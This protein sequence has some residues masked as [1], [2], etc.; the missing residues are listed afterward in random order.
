MMGDKNRGRA[1]RTREWV[2]L[3]SMALLS[4]FAIVFAGCGCEGGGDGDGNDNEGDDDQEPETKPLWVPVDLDGDE[5]LDYVLERCFNDGGQYMCKI[6]VRSVENNSLVFK[7]DYYPSIP[8]FFAE[9]NDY[10]GDSGYEIALADHYVDPGTGDT[11]CWVKIWDTPSFDLVFDFEDLCAYPFPDLWLDATGDGVLDVVVITLDASNNERLE[12]Y[13]G[14]KDFDLAWEFDGASGHS[15]VLWYGAIKPFGYYGTSNFGEDIPEGVVLADID[16]IANPATVTFHILDSTN[17]NIKESSDSYQIGIGSYYMR[18]IGDFDHD[19]FDEVAMAINYRDPVTLD[20]EATL[21]VLDSDLQELFRFGPVADA[22][23]RVR[24]YDFDNDGY[25]DIGLFSK[26]ESGS[27]TKSLFSLYRWQ[28]GDFERVSRVEPTLDNGLIGGQIGYARGVLGKNGYRNSGNFGGDLSFAFVIWEEALGATQTQGKY[29]IV[30]GEKGD[31]LLESDIVSFGAGGFIFYDTSD[32]TGDGVLELIEFG[33]GDIGG[34]VVKG[35]VRVIDVANELTLFNHSEDDGYDD[36]WCS[37][38]VDWNVDG[39]A[40]P[41]CY[42]NSWDA[43]LAPKINIW[44]GTADFSELF[45]FVGNPGE[46]AELILAP[47]LVEVKK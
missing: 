19:G 22:T 40:D 34:G 46:V 30:S 12:V 26:V 33:Y 29:Y 27:V 20:R 47:K 31:V 43:G 11:I 14:T 36:I 21:Y 37:A 28:D 32:F 5:K 10:D 7:S 45:S 6:E 9:I 3:L 13:D 18:A 39:I 15:Y 25:P 41:K 17:G 4:S 35:N 24:P 16:I 44:D 23:V 1:M 42:S 38:Y 2:L 8:L